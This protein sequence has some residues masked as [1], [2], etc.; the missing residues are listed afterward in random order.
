MAAFHP[1]PSLIQLPTL[2]KVDRGAVTTAACL[3]WACATLATGFAPSFYG[4]L[5]F[6]I[7]QGVSQGFTNPA[8]FGILSDT[9]VDA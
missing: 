6:R 2:V 1:S 9:Y 4:V 7:I 5:L 8:A 3:V